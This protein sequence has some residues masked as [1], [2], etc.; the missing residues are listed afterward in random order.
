MHVC[1]VVML[2]LLSKVCENPLLCT[3]VFV[4]LIYPPVAL[5]VVLNCDPPGLSIILASSIVTV[6]VLEEPGV[7]LPIL[8]FMDAI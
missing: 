2:D 4:S 1:R 6:C 7:K 3:G 5:S 8:G